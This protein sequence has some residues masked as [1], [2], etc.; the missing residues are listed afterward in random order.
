MRSYLNYVFTIGHFLHIMLTNL[1]EAF[2][3]LFHIKIYHI[4]NVRT[5]QNCLSS[6][7]Y[8]Y[9]YNQYSYTI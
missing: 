5:L 3:L 2:T 1:N 7:R 9:L 6:I 8:K 4:T